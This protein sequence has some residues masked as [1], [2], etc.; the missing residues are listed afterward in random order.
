MAPHLE[1]L[2]SPCQAKN[3]DILQMLQ[4]ADL[5]VYQ[6]VEWHE[7][8]YRKLELH[9]RWPPPA[10]G[11]MPL[12]RATT[13]FADSLFLH[14]GEARRGVLASHVSLHCVSSSQD[15]TLAF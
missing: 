11:G 3:S 8:V 4:R 1:V 13:C 14:S 10:A 5:S 7:T 9:E 2:D 12:P 15:E 6:K